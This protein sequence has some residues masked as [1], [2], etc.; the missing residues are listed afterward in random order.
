M[1]AS[2][3]GRPGFEELSSRAGAIIETAGFEQ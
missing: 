1:D 3:D 2:A